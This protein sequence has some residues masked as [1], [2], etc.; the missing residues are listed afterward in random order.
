VVDADMRKPSIHKLSSKKNDLGLSS[1][2]TTNQHYLEM[3][4]QGKLENLEILTSGPNAP[5]P[6]A[7]L[8]SEKFEQ[9][10]N[11]WRDVYD[12]VLVDT[13]PIGIGADTITVANKVDSVILSVGMEK[14]TRK[15]V[16]SSMETLISNQINVGGCIVN[17]IESKHDYYN[18]YN[19]YYYYS[20]QNSSS[21]MGSSQRGV[22]RF[23]NY[24][25]RR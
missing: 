11:Q 21:L 23:L 14:T 22:N 6:V 10:I 5:N 13:P 9:L 16:T 15:M 19:Y 7:L 12:Y 20:N 18:Y 24:F 25:R 17:L 1:A 8:D 4:Q 2:I 3:T